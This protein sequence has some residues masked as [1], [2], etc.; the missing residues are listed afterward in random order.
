MLEVRV[1]IHLRDGI[2]MARTINCIELP[3]QN[4]SIT[5]DV[6][7]SWKISRVQWRENRTMMRFYPVCILQFVTRDD[8]EAF[9]GKEDYW[10]D[11]GFLAVRINAN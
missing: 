5:F 1:E 8:A 3:R 10:F 4:D 7:S 11:N 9:W 2:K 6:D